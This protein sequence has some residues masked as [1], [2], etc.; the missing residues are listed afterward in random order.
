MFYIITS[1]WRS[2]SVKMEV[3][4]LVQVFK[5]LTVIATFLIHQNVMQQKCF[6]TEH[7]YSL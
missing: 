6:Y 4:I 5:D 7:Y 3:K 2:E 1:M